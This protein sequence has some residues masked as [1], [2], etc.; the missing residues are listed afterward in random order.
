MSLNNNCK[1]I[2]ICGGIG[3]G[4]SFISS[5]IKENYNIN[6]LY[7]DNLAKEI[8]KQKTILDRIKKEF[9]NDIVE[10]NAINYQKLRNLIFGDDYFRQRINSIIHPEVIKHILAKAEN[11]KY[12]FIE[13]AIPITS[14][15]YKLG[16]LIYIDAPMEDRYNRLMQQRNMTKKDCDRIIMAQKID[17]KAKNI[18][19]LVITNTDNKP[20][21]IKLDRYI[22]GIKNE[23]V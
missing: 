22:K 15:I 9:G 20:I 12:L 3:S 23:V 4:K 11:S 18:A 6:V 10:N 8:M 14:G 21:D 13:T 1:I 5:Y 17:D 7:C 19:K 16:D 2:I